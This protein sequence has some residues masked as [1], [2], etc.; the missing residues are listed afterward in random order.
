MGGADLFRGAREHDHGPAVDGS[1][2]QPC[3]AMNSPRAGHC[4]EDP[5]DPSQVP[6]SGGC[7][8]CRLLVAKP[9]E[10]NSYSLYEHQHSSYCMRLLIGEHRQHG[11]QLNMP[12]Q[13][14][15]AFTHILQA[16]GNM[17]KTAS[18]CYRRHTYRVTWRSHMCRTS[19]RCAL[20]LRRST[21]AQFAADSV[22]W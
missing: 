1:M 15:S 16:G 18:P 5:W 17:S 2:G 11:G 7:I 14:S 6:T 8:P 3:D 9:Y 20:A 10:P 13:P 21:Y 4:Q 12:F 22:P 19:Q